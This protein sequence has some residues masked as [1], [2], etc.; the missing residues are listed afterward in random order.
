MSAALR[1]DGV[2]VS[3]GGREVLV[4]VSF[5]V[6]PGEVVALLGRNG[7]GK[8]TLLRAATRSLSARRG[9]IRVRGTAIGS[10]SPPATSSPT[11]CRRPT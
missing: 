7:A 2:C 1:F 6:E 11:R 3:L 10:L 9:E 8:T 5:S 4:D